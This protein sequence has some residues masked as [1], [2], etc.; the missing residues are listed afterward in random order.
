[1]WILFED[2]LARPSYPLCVETSNKQGGCVLKIRCHIGCTLISYHDNIW[3][4][5]TTH[6]LSHNIPTPQDIAAT[7]AL[8]SECEANDETFPIHKLLTLAVVK[9]EPASDIALM[10]RT[11]SA[12]C[13]WTNTHPDH[14]MKQTIAKWIP[15][16]CILYTTM[17][18]H[19]FRALTRS[20]DLKCPNFGRKATIS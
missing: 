4:Y 2:D 18:T 13:Y 16:D 6:I 14:R 3:T 10:Q 17:E 11:F 20:L 8:A 5:A 7:T 9:T 19:T 15:M 12:P 1:M